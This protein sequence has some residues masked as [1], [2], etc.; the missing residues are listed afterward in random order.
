[1]VSEMLQAWAEK[2]AEDLSPEMLSA[3][4]ESAAEVADT[5]EAKQAVVDAKLEKEMTL[6]KE[7]FEEFRPRLEKSA[8]AMSALLETY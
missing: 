2:R 1:M 8:W 4:Q 7:C 6:L 5:D 3:T